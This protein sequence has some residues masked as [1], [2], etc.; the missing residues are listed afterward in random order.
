MKTRVKIWSA[1]ISVG[2]SALLAGCGVLTAPDPEPTPTP[3]PTPKP[4]IFDPKAY[5][6]QGIAL[7]A[8]GDPKLPEY[9]EAVQV[10]SGNLL[11]VRSVDV[12][13]P[14]EPK[15]KG[16]GGAAP[17]AT[18]ASPTLTYGA[19]EIVELAGVAVPDPHHP[20]PSQRQGAR[21]SMTT[22]Q[23]WTH[24]PKTHLPRK[25]TVQ[26]DP[27]YPVEFD[28]IKLRAVNA[29]R[30]KPIPSARRV[31]IFFDGGSGDNKT[32]LNLN[33]LMIRSGY[34]VVDEH[35]PTIFDTIGW[36]NDEE[37]ARQSRLGLWKFGIVLNQ[38]QPPSK[39]GA[40][41][42]PTPAPAKAKPPVQ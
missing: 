22:L 15:T 8:P 35:E 19:P 39:P 5:T 12:V 2:V 13:T 40:T 25:L 18:P 28:P 16:K 27:K 33:R 23:N 31:Q 21:E 7:N 42:T 38:R 37:Y 20:D 24:D 29:T 26:Q 11:A 9:F 4:D 1:V 34:A 6:T 36:L 3:V 10:Y 41:P 14:P 32:S 30:A 17:A